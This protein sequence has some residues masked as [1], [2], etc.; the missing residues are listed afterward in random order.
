MAIATGI[1]SLISGGMGVAKLVLEKSNTKE[2][3][4][5]LDEWTK[6]EKDAL[7]AERLVDLEKKK[8]QKEQFDSV[9]EH[10]EEKAEHLHK[11]SKILEEAAKKELQR[12]LAA[13]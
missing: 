2:S 11:M 4:K 5:Y 8:P 12:M 6:A 3:R 1:M 10:F 13:Q 9:V 7:E